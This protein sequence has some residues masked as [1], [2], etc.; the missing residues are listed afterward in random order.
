[1]VALFIPWGMAASSSIPALAIA[2]GAWVL[3]MAVLAI[4][5]AAL[6]SSV[7]KLRMY[8][9]PEYLGMATAA[10]ILA[11]VFTAFKR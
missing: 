5:L 2:A 11:V 3:K 1:L 8:L 4:A 10:S 9:V 7:A 6:E